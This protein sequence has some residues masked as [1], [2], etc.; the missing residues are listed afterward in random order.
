M[1]L[2]YHEA[3]FLYDLWKPELTY[4]INQF[5]I[6]ECMICSQFDFLK[7]VSFSEAC[8]RSLIN[9]K[10]LS[11]ARDIQLN[12]SNLLGVVERGDVRHCYG[13]HDASRHFARHFVFRILK[14]SL[15]CR[16]NNHRFVNKVR[17][18]AICVAR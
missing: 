2:S 10:L 6:R 17:W 14:E 1:T 4:L 7:L 9:E 18:V 16:S 3:L 13:A 11:V 8:G 15:H 12:E 5:V